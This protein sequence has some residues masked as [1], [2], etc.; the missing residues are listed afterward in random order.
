MGAVTRRA[1]AMMTAAAG[2]GVLAAGLVVAG[3]GPAVATP[4]VQAAPATTTFSYTGAEQTYPVPAG[5]TAVTVTAVGAPGAFPGS[6]LSGFGASVTATVPLPAGTATLYVEVGGPGAQ[7]GF[8]GGGSAGGTGGGASDVRTVSCGSPCQTTDPGSLASRLV[9]AGGGGGG[10]GNG[11]CGAAGGTA[12]DSTVTGPGNGGNGGVCAEGGT[13]GNG[14]LGGTAGGTGGAAELTSCNGNPGLLGQG[15]DAPTS[16]DTEN[17]GGGGGGGYYGGGAGGDAFDLGGGGGGAGSS[18]WVSGATGTSMSE[19]TT[20]TPQV[21]ITPVI[22]ELALT[23]SAAPATFNAAGQVLTYSYQVSNTGNVAV[24]G[25]GVT[26][27]A[28]PGATCPAPALPAGS[29]ETCTGSYTT[30]SADLTAGKITDAATAGGTAAGMPVTSNTATVTVTKGWPPLVSGSFRP[31]AGAAEGYY[32]GAVN[33][34]WKLFVTHPGTTKVAFTGKITVPAGR[35]GHLTLINPTSGH[36]VTITSRAITF[37]L[38]DYGK[39]TGFSFTTSTKVPS[40][41]FTL[42]IG[43]HPATATQINLG[44]PPAHPGSGSPLTFTR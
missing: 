14:G 20:G 27:P 28:V 22:P 16:C 19:D 11:S 30:T 10:G 34:T 9:V 41:T 26:D 7:G 43:G 8:N 5:A 25:I 1:A 37:S 31:A 2:A 23:V 33:N 36:Q 38:P 24:T 13:G 12:G 35:L 6:I 21:Q 15:G 42:T 4:A 18:F 44:N 3:V 39:V 32:L 29:S 40:I 17:L